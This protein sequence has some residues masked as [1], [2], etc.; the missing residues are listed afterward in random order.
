MKP[1]FLR[2]VRA[3][4]RA[5]VLPILGSAAVAAAAMALLVPSGGSARSQVAP[6]NTVEPTIAGDAAEGNTLRASPGEWSGTTPIMFEYQWLRCNGSGD[7]CREVAGETGQTFRLGDEDVGSRIRVRV[8]ASNEDGSA[9]AFANPTAVVRAVGTAPRN[10]APPTITGTPSV[11]ATLTANPGSWTGTQ[12]I[13]FA[14]DWQR[15]DRNG[16]SCSSI[17]G[18]TQRTYTLKSVDA[19]NTLRVRVTATNRVGSA[20]TTSAPTA[21]TAGTPA[22]PA[23]GC[24]SGRGT[25]QVTQVQPPARLLVDGQQITPAVVSRSTR[26]IVARFHV[27]NTC[28]QTVQGALVYLTAVPYNQFSVP[29]EAQTGADGWATLRMTRLSGF[30]ATSKQQLLV[31]FVRA[32]KSGE[33]VLTGIS[34]R[35]L[36]SFRVALSS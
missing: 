14:Y 11:G 10:T 32:R 9:T 33:S 25:V 22:P 23:T 18:A 15:C 31:F 24:P 29:P 6:S 36:V 28:G 20:G 4:R 1:S 8:T 12:P 7:R 17:S 16:G 13:G 30:P 21:A 35:R 19:G 34:T 2:H 3:D 26:E 27:S 5:A